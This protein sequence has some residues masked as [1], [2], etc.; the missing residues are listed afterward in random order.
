MQDEYYT[1]TEV[2]KLL[3]VS[4]PTVYKW[5]EAGIV[6]G[7][8][9]GGTVRV[10]RASVEAAIQRIYPDDSKAAAGNNPA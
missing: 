3:K 10:T 1:P 5:I 8:R 9:I 6:Q 7:V 4:R 2:S